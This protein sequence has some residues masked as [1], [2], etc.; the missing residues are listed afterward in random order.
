MLKMISEWP[1]GFAQFVF[2]EGWLAFTTFLRG[3]TV[4]LSDDVRGLTVSPCRNRL[5]LTAWGRMIDFCTLWSPSPLTFYGRGR[6]RM[7]SVHLAHCCCFC[8]GT[9]CTLPRFVQVL[10]LAIQ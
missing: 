6:V 7:T 9:F 8:A 4:S 2:T 10:T 1:E 5:V 3:L